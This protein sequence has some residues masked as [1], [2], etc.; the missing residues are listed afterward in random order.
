M[1]Q[2]KYKENVVYSVNPTPT[3]SKRKKSLKSIKKGTSRNQVVNINTCSDVR[4]ENN[5]SLAN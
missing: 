4:N 2:K 1:K 3:K 5:Y